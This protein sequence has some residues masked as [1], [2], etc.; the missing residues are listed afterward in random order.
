MALSVAVLLTAFATQRASATMVELISLDPGV[1][2]TIEQAGVE[3]TPFAGVYNVLVDSAPFEA[4]CVGL[5]NDVSILPYQA[6]VEPI[7]SING[8]LQAGW[9][10]EQYL[11]EATDD[12]HAAALQLAIWEVVED[13][14]NGYDLSSG[15]FRVIDFADLVTTAN[16]YLASIPADITP[17]PQ[18]VVLHSD[19]SQDML[20]PEPAVWMLFLVSLVLIPLGKRS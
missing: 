12:Q 9:L 13:W 17:P 6:T 3:R 15:D 16:T 1:Y 2:V 7:T 8:G 4:F 10:Y 5:G 18:A 20:I 19:E 11:S 14:D